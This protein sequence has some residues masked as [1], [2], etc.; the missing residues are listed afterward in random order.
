[1]DPQYWNKPHEFNPDRFLDDDNKLIKNPA[2]IPFS[3][4][5]RNCVAESVGKS[6]LFLFFSNLIAKFEFKQECESTKHSFLPQ[7]GQMITLTPE[8]YTLKCISVE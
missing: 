7:K 2:L 5:P 8:P 4:G 6:E 1:M 3:I